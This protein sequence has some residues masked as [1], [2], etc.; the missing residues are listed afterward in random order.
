MLCAIVSLRETGQIKKANTILL[1]LDEHLQRLPEKIPVNSMTAILR[2][3]GRM[4]Y[5]IDQ[6]LEMPGIFS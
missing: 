6:N 2:M 1:N 5:S 4:D 3:E